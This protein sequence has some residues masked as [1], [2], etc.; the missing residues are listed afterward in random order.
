MRVGRNP[1]FRVNQRAEVRA[2][3]N[4]VLEKAG[5]GVRSFQEQSPGVPVAFEAREL[6]PRQTFCCFRLLGSVDRR[7]SL[8][9]DVAQL[10]AHMRKPLR[11]PVE[12]DHID[13]HE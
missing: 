1:A 3:M 11:M 9:S 5:M 4:V 10:V 8:K 12:I 6:E 2:E 13:L 7:N